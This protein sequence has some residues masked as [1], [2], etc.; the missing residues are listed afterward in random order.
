MS[1]TLAEMLY[2]ASITEIC[3][4]AGVSQPT[5]TRYRQAGK[6]SDTPT[7]RK[8]VDYLEGRFAN[9]EVGAQRGPGARAVVAREP[10]REHHHTRDVR[11]QSRGQL[12]R[13][14][15]AQRDVIGLGRESRAVRAVCAVWA[16]RA[17]GHR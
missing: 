8:V 15:V 9:G 7:G 11:H 13:H 10:L 6:V 16:A 5:V 14:A 2:A 12:R 17:A 3:G 4:G 1:M